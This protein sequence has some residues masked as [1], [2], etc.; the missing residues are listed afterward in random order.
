M[1]EEDYRSEYTKANDRLQ[2][3]NRA[4][5]P[6]PIDHNDPETYE[7]IEYVGYKIR[8]GWLVPPEFL[9]EKY[10]QWVRV[11][12]LPVT[13]TSEH[14]YTSGVYDNAYG[15]LVLFCIDAVYDQL[16]R[17]AWSAQVAQQLKAIERSTDTKP[18]LVTTK[19]GVRIAVFG[20]WGFADTPSVRFGLVV[21][22]VDEDGEYDEN[23]QER[24]ECA[25]ALIEFWYNP[26]T[27]P[28]TYPDGNI[29]IYD[30]LLWWIGAINEHR[31]AQL[32]SMLERGDT[33][34]WLPP[35]KYQPHTTDSETGKSVPAFTFFR[36]HPYKEENKDA[37]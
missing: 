8:L 17:R 27:S 20:F 30:L 25:T 33:P 13:V 23:K 5:K 32:T 16:G 26:L 34:L 3:R 28:V 37:Q 36:E 29:I 12:S 24:G 22:S 35:E 10:Q 15:T 7:E 11:G 18:M 6:R 31:I 2:S 9:D 1:V 21:S 19:D 14:V 4:A